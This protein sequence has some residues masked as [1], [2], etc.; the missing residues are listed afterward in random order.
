MEVQKRGSIHFHLLVFGI[1][2]VRHQ[3]VA[4]NWTDIVA[5]GDV[6]QLKAGTQVNRV[7]SYGEARHYLEKYLSKQES[8]SDDDDQAGPGSLDA[9]GRWWGVRGSLGAFKAPV[10][11]ERIDAYALKQLARTLDKLNKARVRSIIAAKN[12]KGQVPSWMYAW[13]RKRKKR[14][15]WQTSRWS[16][17]A[18]CL[19]GRLPDLIGVWDV[20]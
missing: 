4:D 6:E 12:A 5:P 10:H 3:W 15:L 13:S 17:D 20:T 8:S 16:L 1:P 2:F 7:K 11:E 14:V 19:V 18:S 9:P